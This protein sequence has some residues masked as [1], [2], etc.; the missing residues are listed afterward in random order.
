M[1]NHYLFLIW[2]SVDNINCIRNTISQKFTIKNEIIFEWHPN[3]FIKNLR[4]FYYKH[5]I[6]AHLKSIETSKKKFYVFIVYDQNPNYSNLMIRDNLEH[7]NTNIYNMKLLLRRKTNGGHKIHSSNNETEFNENMLMLNINNINVL[8]KN[9]IYLNPPGTIYWSSIKE[10]LLFLGK[11]M[12]YVVM[13]GL[14]NIFNKDK[15]NDDIDILVENKYRAMQILNAKKI[16]RIKFKSAFLLTI[17]DKYINIDIRDQNDGYYCKNWVKNILKTKIKL[18]EINI[19]SKI[20]LK[21]MTIYHAI[22]H[23]YSTPKKYKYLCN[24]KSKNDLVKFMNKNKYIYTEPHDLSVAFSINKLRIIQPISYFRI[25]YNTVKPLKKY[26]QFF[27]YQTCL[28]KIRKIY[29]A[30]FLK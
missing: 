21:Y 28:T 15:N 29:A 19:P 4:R 6:N 22:I 10:A 26:N 25:F 13:R 14:D 1:K 30:I 3:I 7:V 5:K 18:N 9:Y 11:F 23:K 20:N 2:G 17:K 27:L 24:Y 12:D 8:K 16:Q